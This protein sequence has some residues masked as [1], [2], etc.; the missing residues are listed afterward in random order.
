MNAFP[1]RL[2]TAVSMVVFLVWM[3]FVLASLYAVQKPFTPVT[4]AALARTLW[5]AL[6]PAVIALC[7]ALLGRRIL[8]T[9]GLRANSRLEQALYGLGIGSG[10]LAILIFLLGASGLLKP[11]LLQVLFA[12]GAAYCL[13]ELILHRPKRLCPA[14]LPLPP[15]WMAAYFIWMAG[16]TLLI[17]LA[18][19]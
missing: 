8:T 19:P 13:A 7:A 9:A 11:A 4:G 15:W 1:R 10:I 12:A 14:E 3:A 17:A 6:T 2:V 18:P 16:L 5:S